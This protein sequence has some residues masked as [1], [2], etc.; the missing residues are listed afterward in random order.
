M[1]DKQMGENKMIFTKGGMMQLIRDND[2][3]ERG[4]NKKNILEQFDME[5]T[6]KNRNMIGK[7]AQELKD[8]DLIET[9]SLLSCDGGYYGRGYILKH[10]RSIKEVGNEQ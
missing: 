6:T 10:G 2:R 9:V 1:V 5:D 7:V 3:C 4:T 8:L